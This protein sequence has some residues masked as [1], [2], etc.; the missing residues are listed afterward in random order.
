MNT[1]E[2]QLFERIG[3]PREQQQYLYLRH[4]APLLD[5]DTVQLN[6]IEKGCGNAN[7]NKYLSPPISSKSAAMN[8][9]RINK[10]K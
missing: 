6:K 9:C 3:I 8:E 2:N 4:D 5:M 10:L 1:M 7:G